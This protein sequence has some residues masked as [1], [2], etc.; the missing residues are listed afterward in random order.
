MSA[1]RLCGCAYAC[2]Y[3]GENRKLSH[4]HNRDSFLTIR[5]PQKFAEYEIIIILNFIN[6]KPYE[7][8]NLIFNAHSIE[9]ILILL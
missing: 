1:S 4:E 2:I 3:I 9:R 6:Y 5:V 8:Q 7:N